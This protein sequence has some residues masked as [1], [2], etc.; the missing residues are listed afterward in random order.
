MEFA[1]S[2]SENAPLATAYYDAQ[3]LE[4]LRT[5]S[6]SHEPLAELLVRSITERA[7]AALSQGPYSVIQKTTLPPSGNIHDYWHAS[8][9]DWPNPETPDGLPYVHRDGERVPGT[10]LYEKES[11]RYDRTSLQRMFDGTTVLALAWHFTGGEEYAQKAAELVRT[12]FIDER[13]RMTPHLE[14][15]QVVMGK[16]GNQGRN[17]GV[18]ETKDFYFFLDAV[19]LIRRSGEWHRTDEAAMQTWCKTFLEWL[20]N[21]R[22]GRLERVTPNNHGVCYDL[23]LAA[24]AAY[25]GDVTLVKSI[26]SSASARLQ[27]HFAKDGRQPHELMRKTTFHYCA[28]NLQ[29]WLNLATVLE[30]ICGFRLWELEVSPEHPLGGT[31]ARL[32]PRRLKGQPFLPLKNAV[33]WIL[34]YYR[35]PWEYPQLDAFN[36]ERLVPI[37]YGSIRRDPEL[38]VSFNDWFPEL[39]KAEPCYFP[40]DGIP[41]F[42]MI[43]EM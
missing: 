30:N 17:Y 43:N 11:E 31:F 25:V 12:W 38:A 4:L 19:R 7:Q 42:W 21:S 27:K 33:R 34:P 5:R 3:Q 15:A 28:F 2:P 13:T 23:Q 20:Q 16:N 18:I 36:K 22:Q 41:V 29:S 37:Y 35:Q 6:Q 39:A 14:Y 32:L 1:E 9:Y 10:Q 24:L 26:A 40:H 8:P